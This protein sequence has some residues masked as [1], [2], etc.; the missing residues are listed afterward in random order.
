MLALGKRNW[1]S[2]IVVVAVLAAAMVAVIP[3][4]GARSLRDFDPAR[5]ANLELR[6]WQAYY[7]KENVR[8]FGLLVQL[9]REQYHYSWAQAVLQGSRLARAA[10]RFGNAT[11]DY[12]RSLPELTDAYAAARR[13]FGAS[14]DPAAVARAE[15]AWWVARRIPGQNAPE[16]VGELIAHE[17]ALLYE[18]PIDSVREAAVLRARAAWLRDNQAASPDWTTVARLLDESYRKLSAALNAGTAQVA[19]N[20]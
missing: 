13:R 10:A 14:F 17:Y 9:L 12:E 8:L 20:L 7:S 16:Q 5:T 1:R 18:A 3:P 6:M 4:G 2:W 15:L 19:D 11:S